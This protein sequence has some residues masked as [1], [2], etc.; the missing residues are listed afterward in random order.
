MRL[1]FTFAFS[2]LPNQLT[3]EPFSRFPTYGCERLSYYVSLC[4]DFLGSK[5]EMRIVPV[6]HN[7]VEIR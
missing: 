5:A 7:C 1:S 2:L 6:S 4:L 3:V